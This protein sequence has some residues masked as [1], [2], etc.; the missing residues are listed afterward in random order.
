M[1]TS[2][3]EGMDPR[4]RTIQPGGGIV[5]RIELAWGT[6][7]RLYLWIF[8]RGYIRRMERLRRGDFNPAPHPVF[9]PRDLKFYRNQGGWNWDPRDDPFKWRDRLPFARAGLAELLLFSLL[10]FVPA[11][12]CLRAIMLRGATGGWAWFFGLDALALLVIGTL[13]VWF[14]RDPQRRIPDGPGVVVSPADGKVVEVRDVEHDE[15][16]GGPAVHIGIF[17]SIF[18]VHINR[19]PVACRI[20]SLAY[21]PGRFLNALRP[22]SARENEQLIVHLKESGPMRRKMI[23]RQITGA[24]ARRIVCWCRPGDQFAIGERFGMIKLGSRTEIVVPKEG[25]E[26]AVLI[27]DHVKAG[28]SVIGRYAATAEGSES[29]AA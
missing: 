4:I 21:E 8:R 23:V 19:V 13:I 11:I 18:N 26:T 24:I 1:H 27:G 12:L 28:C 15:F 20:V 25:F 22:E 2:A 10:T 6:F 7:R 17:L 16:I 29:A 5:M 14:F 9:D 3:P